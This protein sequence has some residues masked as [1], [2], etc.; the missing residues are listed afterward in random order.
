MLSWSLVIA[1]GACLLWYKRIHLAT[2]EDERMLFVIACMAGC[3]AVA[4][5]P[6]GAHARLRLSNMM[7]ACLGACAGFTLLAG[8]PGA[9]HA[10]GLIGGGVTGAVVWYE[11]QLAGL[12]TLPQNRRAMALAA[13]FVWS[14]AV[15]VT[16]DMPS[17]RAL[18]VRGAWP[19]LTMAVLALTVAALVL[20]TRGHVF[21]ARLVPVIAGDVDASRRLALIGLVAVVSFVLLCASLGLQQAII[22]PDAVI[23]GAPTGP[24]QYLTIPLWLGCAWV[25]DRVGRYALV[26]AAMLGSFVTAAALFDPASA[27]LAAV[28]N[29]GIVF[30]VV[31]YS[32]CCVAMIADA[33]CYSRRPGPLVALSFAPAVTLQV[34][35]T[36]ARPLGR[37]LSPVALVLLDLAVLTVFTATAAILLEI[38]QRH[39]AVLQSA[40]LLVEVPPGASPEPDL[41]GAAERYGLTKWEKE[42]LSLSLA[43]LTVPQM[44]E[45]LFVTPATVK[46]HITNL[47]RKTGTTSRADLAA[48]LLPPDPA[49]GPR[50]GGLL[51]RPRRRARV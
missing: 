44:A 29:A 7:L 23:R 15:S 42:I 43:G 33:A 26:V 5:I 11:L 49:D 8:A 36:V 45:R 51:V 25:A 40:T 16:T 32:T 13:Q 3:L 50:P 4:L 46:T 14:D 48:Q 12:R 24:V 39:V 30:T 47:L 28:G 34:V 18:Y 20:A 41:A 6:E 38:L 2:D 37:E 21:D 10:A 17:L 22:R 35:S 19:N 27:V 9:A 31:A 1:G